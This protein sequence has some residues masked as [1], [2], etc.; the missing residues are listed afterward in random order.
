MM[1][2]LLIHGNLKVDNFLIYKRRHKWKVNVFLKSMS[3]L[4]IKL[5]NNYNPKITN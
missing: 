4:M 3:N 5:S 1:P 2:L